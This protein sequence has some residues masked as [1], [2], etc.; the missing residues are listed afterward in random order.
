MSALP[1]ARSGSKGMIPVFELWGKVLVIKSDVV[2]RVDEGN[3]LAA[4]N[5]RSVSG[6]RSTFPKTALKFALPDALRHIRIIGRTSPGEMPEPLTLEHPLVKIVSDVR[7]V[8]EIVRRRTVGFHRLHREPR[9]VAEPA[10]SYRTACK[11]GRA[12]VKNTMGSVSSNLPEDPVI[13]RVIGVILERAARR[14]LSASKRRLIR[15]TELLTVVLRFDEQ[16]MPRGSSQLADLSR[17]CDPRPHVNI[18]AFRDPLQGRQVS[19]LI[20]VLRLSRFTDAKTKHPQ[21]G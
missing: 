10:A 17:V 12:P 9:A 18:Q 3:N 7:V 13:L 8:V 1:Q 19:L 20:E 15:K 2:V 5:H 21:L 11:I 14:I 16:T 4:L 6:F